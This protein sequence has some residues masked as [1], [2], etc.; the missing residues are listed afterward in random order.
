MTIYCIESCYIF[1]TIDRNEKKRE[2]GGKE[3]ERERE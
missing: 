3:G 2:G 1:K